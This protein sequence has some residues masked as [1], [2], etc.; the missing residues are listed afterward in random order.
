[1]ILSELLISVTQ[2]S[3]Y[4]MEIKSTFPIRLYEDRKNFM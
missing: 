4:K 2:F 1:M 3:I